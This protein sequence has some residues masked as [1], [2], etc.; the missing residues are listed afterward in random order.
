MKNQTLP[1]AFGDLEPYLAWSLPTEIERRKQRLSSSMDEI[2]AFYQAMF[3]RLEDIINYLNQY[4]YTEM[5]EDAQR[6]C[7]L[8]LSHVEISN[9]VEMYKRP[10]NMNFMDLERF[11]PHE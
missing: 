5:P 2:Q 10:E 4:P 1:E 3:A 11:V 6:L 8:G 9:L 7:D